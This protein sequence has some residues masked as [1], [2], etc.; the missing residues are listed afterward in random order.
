MAKYGIERLAF[1]N[2]ADIS[3]RLAPNPVEGRMELRSS[4]A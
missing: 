4:E 3:D 2:E 1:R